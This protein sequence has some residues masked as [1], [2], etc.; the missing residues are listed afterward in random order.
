[1]P[2]IA[3]KN[4]RAICDVCQ[5]KKAN[6]CLLCAEV[7]RNFNAATANIKYNTK[8]VWN[9]FESP[10]RFCRPIEPLLPDNNFNKPSIKWLSTLQSNEVTFTSKPLQLNARMKKT[11]PEGRS[12]FDPDIE[13]SVLEGDN[14]SVT[15]INIIPKK[16][17]PTTSHPIINK[18]SDKKEIKV[19]KNQNYCKLSFTSIKE[20]ILT[21]AKT[22]SLSETKPFN[23][24]ENKKSTEKNQE[25]C[26]MQDLVTLRKRNSTAN[27]NRFRHF[28]INSQ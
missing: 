11:S 1:M 21:N 26:D 9:N 16:L 22:V 18:N 24:Q 7:L 2:K 13:S 4:I 6:T 12:N 15:Y 23:G 20:N 17:P 25:I 14:V 28:E 5:T 27:Y 10:S 8:K 19:W 3:A